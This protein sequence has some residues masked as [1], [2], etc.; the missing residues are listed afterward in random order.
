MTTT[1][2][3]YTNLCKSSLLIV[4]LFA[5]TACQ[6]TEEAQSENTE[7]LYATWI[8]PI[9]FNEV[10][11]NDEFWKPRMKTQLETLVPFALDKT[12]P[13][14]S[15]LKKA[16]DFLAGLKT[17]LPKPHRYQSSDLYKV[18]EGAAYLLKEYDSPVIERRMDSI[19]NI[20]G[21]AQKEDG[22]LYVPHITRM[23]AHHDH[24]GG[25]GMGDLPYSFVLHSH[26]LYNM[27]HMY[28]GAMAYYQATGK[29]SWLKIAEKNAQHI[30]RVF[31]E[32][33]PNYNHGQ[34]VNQAPG[35]QEIELALTKMYRLTGNETY[36]DMA[37]KFLDIRAK[38]YQPEGE[39]VMSPSYAQQHLPVGEQYKAVG[40]AV[41]AGYQYSAMAEV[42]ALTNN[43]LFERALDSL[44]HDLV[45]KKFSITGGL[46][47][48]RGI[49]G[50]GPAYVLPNKEAYNET[51]AAVA[52]VFFNYRMFL[53]TGDAK[54]IDVAEV[55][56]MNNALAGVN[57]DGNRFF[58][59]NPL[60]ADGS[61]G[62]NH[63]QTGRSPWFNTACC[64]S[65]IARLI[66][67]VPG[68]MYAH[69]EREIFV[70]LYATN[71]VAIP[72]ENSEVHIEQ[73]SNYPFDGQI[74]LKLFPEEDSK[75]VVKL[76]IP[77]WAQGKQFVPGDLYYYAKDYED[78]YT[79]EINGERHLSS[80][81]NGYVSLDR[82]WK[83][84]D[85]IKLELPIATRFTKCHPLVESNQGRIAVTRGPLVYA[86]EEIDNKGPV[87]RYYMES[88]PSSQYIEES[89]V[90]QGILSNMVQMM[91]PAIDRN[92]QSRPSNLTLVPYFA[93]NNRGDGS[94]IVWIP[95]TS[96]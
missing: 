32:G 23:S 53:M 34:P 95:V 44:W 29:D 36:L 70:N 90:D 38:T 54:Y 57:M 92:N 10:E 26:E 12:I 11:L 14:Q 2:I 47:A 24:W 17:E 8:K 5:V 18:M 28:E 6:N 68:M 82:R 67:Q 88:L 65:N 7:S 73:S 39:G 66:P 30:N 87:Q 31:F 27:G 1:L 41:R 48:V 15:A 46:G 59:V 43:N 22:Y 42:D 93:W 75:F 96:I 56:L 69:N 80:I 58:Y 77:T 20:I 50:F 51:C 13:A 62:F 45:D 3:S 76:R 33:D 91:I 40:H 60:E 71:A 37:K 52:N 89:K 78:T 64:P 84:G 86:A 81:K 16:G 79:I 9:P 83:S 19:I 21:R 94:M 61:W 55:S 49:E 85:M 72:F 74:L 35:H 4:V 63:N 25:G